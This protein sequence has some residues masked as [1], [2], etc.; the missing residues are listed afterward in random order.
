MLGGVALQWLIGPLSDRFGRRPLLLIGCAG[1]TLVCMATYW[2][3]DIHLF[4]VLRLFQGMGLGIVIAVSYP[5]LNEAFSEADAVR[6]MAL[7]ANI[8]LLSPLLGPLLGALLLEWVS[9]RSIFVIIGACGVVVWLG[10][11]RFMPE[12]VGVE[13][14]DGSRLEFQTLRLRPLVSAYAT[15]L[16]NR[17]F[18]AGSIALGLLGLPLIAWIGLSPLLLVR[19]L[20]MSTLEYALWQL[21]VFS[22]LIVGNLLINYAASKYPLPVL[23]QRALW[24]VLGGLSIMMLGALIYP[25]VQIVV[26]GLSLYAV[27]L[28]VSNAV[29]YRITLFASDQSKG[30]V[31]ATLGMITVALLG[32]GGSALALSGAGDNLTVFALTAGAIGFLTLWPLRRT[33][34]CP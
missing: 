6:M 33:L 31:S 8:A 1:F 9:W 34:A 16:G 20:G 3:N 25:S 30:L 15:L 23:I 29:L 28:G 32:L 17:R 12:T 5:A 26:I 22:G 7:L 27:G 18:V 11:Y 21:P 13:R 24:L 19:N 14:R 10:L 2:V 4:N